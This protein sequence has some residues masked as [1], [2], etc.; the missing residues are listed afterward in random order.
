M[1][2]LIPARAGSQRVPG[3]NIKLLAGH[4][5]LA[6]TI[7]S[8]K[9]SGCFEQILV[10]THDHRTGLIAEQYGATYL[11]QPGPPVLHHDACADI[12]WIR[13]A[14][15]RI[16]RPDTFAILRPTSPFRTAATIQ[17]AFAQFR[18]PDSTGDSLRAV[19][20][21]RQHPGKMWEWAG[22]GYPI[23]PL[24][25][26]TR[27]DGIP[28]HSAPTQTLPV[29]YVQNSSLEMAWTACVEAHGSIHGRKVGPFFTKGYEGLAIDY[30]EDWERA[31]GLI[32]TGQVQP[33]LLHTQQASAAPTGDHGHI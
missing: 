31:E 16:Q 9:L 18:H 15:T 19:E 11:W 13:H 10:C 27:S 5:L 21:V 7:T 29:F 25:H 4:P 3:K 2:A 33:D 12:E 30:P 1:V 32:A 20:P 14:L 8:A 22:P 17:R 28:W 24:L 6:Y 26:G 23:T